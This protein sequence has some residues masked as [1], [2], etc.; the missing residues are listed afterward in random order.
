MIGS[1]MIQERGRISYA[2]IYGS[3]KEDKEEECNVRLGDGKI[4][5]D[6]NNELYY[7]ENGVPRTGFSENVWVALRVFHT[8]FA[9]EHS[10]IVDSLNATYP[11]ITIRSMT[12]R[13]F[14]FLLSLSRSILWNEPRTTILPSIYTDSQCQLVWVLRI[15]LLLSSET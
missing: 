2:L 9:G 14:V 1:N 11:K 10:Y 8:I 15:H 13:V 4:H 12:Q 3:S 7:D 5:L 6:E